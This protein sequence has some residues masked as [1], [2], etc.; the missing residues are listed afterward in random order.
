MGDSPNDKYARVLLEVV[1]ASCGMGRRQRRHQE[2]LFRL[3]AWNIKE[4]LKNLLN[5]FIW[6][7]CLQSTV[8][9]H[10][11]GDMKWFSLSHIR[12]PNP[13]DH[14]QKHKTD[15]HG[16]HHGK[17]VETRIS[18]VP[19]KGVEK[20]TAIESSLR[21]MRGRGHLFCYLPNETCGSRLRA[22]V[23]AR[24]CIRQYTMYSVH[25][26]RAWHNVIVVDDHRPLR[27]GLSTQ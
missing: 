1:P 7:P 22:P 24:R 19:W 13:R 23:Q 4:R 15:A 14:Q 21:L 11:V 18:Y 20:Y 26:H 10:K 16:G 3:S 25:D 6:Q 17:V 2:E 8:P 9:P 27:H 12:W 5:L